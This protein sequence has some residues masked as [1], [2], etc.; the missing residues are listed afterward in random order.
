MTRPRIVPLSINALKSALHYD[1]ETGVWTWLVDRGPCVKA[2]SVAGSGGGRR[3]W[4]IGFDGHQHGAHRLAWFYMTGAWP[5]ELVDHRDGNP[6]N[7]RWSNLREATTATNRQNETKPRRNLPKGVSHDPRSKRF[8]AVIRHNGEYHHLGMFGT[9]EE[10]GEAYDRAA[11]HY[12]GSF[13][14]TNEMMRA[15]G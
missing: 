10:A 5:V 12:F 14:Y 13:A 15:A 2:G 1:P 3:Y 8:Q 9:A 6:F 4:Q 11:K 7:N